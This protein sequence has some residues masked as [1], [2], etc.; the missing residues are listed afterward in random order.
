[1]VGDDLSWFLTLADYEHMTDA[2]AALRLPQSTLSR[3]LSRLEAEIGAPLFDRRGRSL[4]LNARGRALQRRYASALH[5]LQRGEAEVRRLMDPATG[6]VRFDFIHSLGT[7]MAPRVLRAFRATYPRADV[8]L[9]QDMGRVLAERVRAD[10]SDVALCS[11]QPSGDDLD[12]MLLMRQPLALAL[13]RD[14]RLAGSASLGLGDLADEAFIATP[15]GYATRT[16]VDEAAVDAGVALRIAYES[17]EL[18]TI[19][20]LVSAGLGVALLPADDP[21]LTASGVALI[22]LDMARYR[23]VGLTWRPENRAVPTVAA[24]LDVAAA[25]AAPPVKYT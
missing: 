20:G 10:E 2:A 9:H 15:S 4:H 5:E 13:P 11:P 17:T 21:T 24:F 12:W 8:R 25:T 18:S 23:E 6:Q 14:H 1:M 22:P 19:A 16:L 7:W 3:R